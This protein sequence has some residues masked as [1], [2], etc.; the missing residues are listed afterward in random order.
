MSSPDIEH[1]KKLASELAAAVP[2]EEA[3]I[4]LTQYG[5]GLDECGIVGNQ[6]GYL[7]LGIEFINL[8]LAPMSEKSHKVAADLRYLMTSDSDIRFDWFERREELA[9]VT[10]AEQ[11][12]SLFFLLCLWLA[13]L[14]AIVVFVIGGG[15]IV[16]WICR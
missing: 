3:R 6:R 16:S 8:A 12:P 2:R 7:R 13:F 1:F 14:S 9:T 5:G 11:K 15:T 4:R 10:Q